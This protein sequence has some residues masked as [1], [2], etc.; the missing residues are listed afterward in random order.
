LVAGVACAAMKE[1]GQTARMKTAVL[2]SRRLC[3]MRR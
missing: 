1:G 3:F 2:V